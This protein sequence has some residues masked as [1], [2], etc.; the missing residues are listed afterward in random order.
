M[1][2]RSTHS[3]LM[4]HYNLH[5]TFLT[6]NGLINPPHFYSVAISTSQITLDL[7][8]FLAN[9]MFQFDPVPTKPMVW[10][11]NGTIY[12]QENYSRTYSYNIQSQQYY[13]IDLV[14]GGNTDDNP[15]SAA[16]IESCQQSF[17]YM[18]ITPSTSAL[19]CN[20]PRHH[21]MK[22]TMLGMAQL[23]LLCPHLIPGSLKFKWMM[24]NLQ[25]FP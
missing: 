1:L 16:A 14:T 9:L 5:H 21:L 3:V 2:H 12:Y 19:P 15:A 6:A 22:P 7:H 25:T 17:A 8:M 24:S 11:R 13:D 4:T 20:R 18:A 23:K 10:T